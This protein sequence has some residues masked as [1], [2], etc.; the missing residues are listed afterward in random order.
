MAPCSQHEVIWEG[1]HSLSS[2]MSL[3]F[4]CSYSLSKVRSDCPGVLVFDIKSSFS[5]FAG[6]IQTQTNVTTTAHLTVIRCEDKGQKHVEVNN[7]SFNRDSK[8]GIMSNKRI[9]SAVERHCTNQTQAVWQLIWIHPSNKSHHTAISSL[10]GYP[11]NIIFQCKL[12]LSPQGHH[13]L[14]VAG[15]VSPQCDMNRKRGQNRSFSIV[16][17]HKSWVLTTGPCDGEGCVVF[18]TRLRSFSD[19]IYEMIRGE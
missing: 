8:M 6:T 10:L 17:Q 4:S 11:H 2:N 14:P 3:M 5:P 18:T 16:F 9:I 12:V 7:N 15:R 19:L 1:S 13:R